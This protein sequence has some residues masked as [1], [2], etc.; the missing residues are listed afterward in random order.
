MNIFPN[1]KTQNPPK[2]K[3]RDTH[4]TL[5]HGSGGKA[6]RDLIQD[7]FVSSFD[8]QILA[9]LEDQASLKLTHLTAQGDRLAFTTDSYVVDPLFFPGSDI[10][11][12]AV[13]GTINDLAVSGATP[14]YLTCSV[15]LE[16]G[17][18][19]ETLRRVVGSMKLAAQKAGVQIVTGDTK[20]VHRGAA[21]KLFIN[22]TG[23]G[24]IP[25]GI[26]IS[27][28]N[29]QVGDVVII[30]GELGNHG[31]AILIA[32]GELALETHIESDCQPLH[33]LV[34]TIL[35]VCPEVHAMRDA[36][37]G[38]LATVLNE[39]S[40]SSDV[41]IRVHEPSIPIREEVQGVCEILGLDPLYLAN[42][43]KLVVV[44]GGNHAETVL[45]AMKSHP[46]GKD[47]CIIGE[48]IASPPGVVLLQTTFGTQRIV[49][50]LVGE[51]LPRIC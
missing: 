22:T 33:S 6:M 27:A 44:V 38:G 45:S 15:I 16:E 41:G 25:E 20:V 37:R 18:P 47:A 40:L 11:E 31:T 43:G 29:I 42:E 21:D 34:K 28:H 30:N 32:R 39:F 35:N 14:L 10:G 50:M 46:A 9:Q 24:V 2:T 5:A 36:T 13:N 19:V 26:N 7:I 49:D 4:I 48:V 17:L 8:N 51:Q 12:L 1:N 3:L 23:I